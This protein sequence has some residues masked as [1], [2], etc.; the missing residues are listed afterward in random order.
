MHLIV[1]SLVVIAL[2]AA[3]PIREPIPPLF[4][5]SG[6]LITLLFLGRKLEGKVWSGAVF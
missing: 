2:T 3:W 1:G 5:I 6:G 4:G